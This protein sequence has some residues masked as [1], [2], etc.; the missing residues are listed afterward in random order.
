MPKPDLKFTFYIS[1]KT[2]LRITEREHVFLLDLRGWKVYI[3]I[4]DNT[5]SFKDTKTELVE[6]KKF[7]ICSFLLQDIKENALVKYTFIIPRIV[8]DRI[9]EKKS[10]GISILK[11]FKGEDINAKSQ[12]L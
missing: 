12:S 2:R 11:W 3:N 5:A 4:K 1:K 8:I 6:R 9:K 7:Y 10:K